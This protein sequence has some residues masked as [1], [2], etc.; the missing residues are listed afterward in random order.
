MQTWMQVARVV[1]CNHAAYALADI[2]AAVV[3]AAT[4]PVDV[5]DEITNVINTFAQVS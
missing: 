4:L 2:C 3:A 5:T 1:M